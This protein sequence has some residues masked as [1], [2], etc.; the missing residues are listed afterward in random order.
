MIDEQLKN[1]KKIS[2]VRR[3]QDVYKALGPGSEAE[4][5]T[6]FTFGSLF[7]APYKG[8]ELHNDIH[9]A[10][11]DQRIQSLIGNSEFLPFVHHKGAFSLCQL[12]L[13]DGQFKNHWKATFLSLKK[14]LQVL[15][16]SGSQ[17]VHIFEMTDLPRGEE[18]D[19]LVKKTAMNLARS[20]N[21]ERKMKMDCPHLRLPDT[22]LYIEESVCSCASL[23]LLVLLGQLLPRV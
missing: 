5:A 11:S 10:R 15:K 17:L 1:K 8:S 3:R 19:G 16:Q 20:L 18:E 7:T 12:W 13:L 14:K 21:G 22:L 23:V 6:V 2:Y 4:S 9:K